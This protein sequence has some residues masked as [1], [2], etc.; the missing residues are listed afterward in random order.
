MISVDFEKVDFLRQ[1]AENFGLRGKKNKKAKMNT[2]VF[3]NFKKF[4]NPNIVEDK[5]ILQLSQTEI[6]RFTSSFWMAAEKMPTRA[7]YTQ[8]TAEI[9][10]SAPES[11]HSILEALSF[12]SCTAATHDM[13]PRVR[14]RD[15]TRG[16]VY[17][18]SHR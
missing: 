15:R 1:L 7:P 3:L 8:L 5:K 6:S 10:D 13:Q 12:S 14:H 2:I 18:A 9:V 4:Q 16:I 11:T 17:P